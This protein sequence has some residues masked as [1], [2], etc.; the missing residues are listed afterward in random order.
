M[1]LSL[2]KIFPWFYDMEQRKLIIDARWFKHLG[3]PTKDYTLTEEEFASYLHPDDREILMNALANQIAG[4]L[5]TEAFTYR[6][7]RS[8][9][10][11]EWFEEQSLYLEQ[12]E[13]APYRII[14]ACQ[15]IQEH[16]SVEQKLMIARD[17]AEQSDKLK[18]AFLANMS[19]E[20]R[21]PLN[22][23]VGFSNLLVSGD[24]EIG[25]SESKEF[26][27]IINKNCEQL[28]VLIS[29]IIDLSK[30][31]SNSIEFKMK[32]Q[33]LNYILSD[34]YQC[35]V[36]NMPENVEF[37]LQQPKEALEIVTDDTLL[38]QVINNLINNA[39]KFTTHG[40]IALGYKA[41]SDN[42]VEIFVNDT[43]IGMSKEKL[44]HIFDRFYKVD[45]FKPGA[46]LGLSISKTIIEH[47][48]GEITVT[49]EEGKGT[50]FT[51][52]IPIHADTI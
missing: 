26:V 36:L 12:I 51:I 35:Q 3:I 34:V 22:A 33:P 29:D 27:S 18:S 20:I 16:K 7:R 39:I 17:K 25:S 1:A 13:G 31:E 24:I 4:I 19:H 48:Q 44:A 15:S 5:N 14:G 32:K 21:T 40:S 47:M 52:T 6:L 10:T 9:G 43:G 28:L 38:K 30:I 8:D 11:W 46:G 23:I 37:I 2:T 50:H 41:L 49:S 45:S 42:T